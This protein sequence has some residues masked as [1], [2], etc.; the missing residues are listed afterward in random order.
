MATGRV[1]HGLILD[2]RQFHSC[3]IT[4]SDVAK[5]LMDLGYH[6]PTLSCPVHGTLMI[7]PTE[8]ESLEELDRFIDALL[9]IRRE[10]Q[11]VIDGVADKVD[12]VLL[13]APHPEYEVVADEWNHQYSRQKAAYPAPWVAANKFW[14]PVGRVDN[15]FG[16]RNLI[17]RF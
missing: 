10:I 1:G 16:D 11:E 12:N 13:N 7:E 2:C 3:G 8:S 15:G 6:V 9:I 14:L 4:E 17:A 5:R